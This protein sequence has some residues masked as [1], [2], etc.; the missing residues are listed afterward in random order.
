MGTNGTPEI[1]RVSGKILGEQAAAESGVTD[2][3]RQEE[4]FTA[5]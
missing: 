1:G 4:S 3:E 5:G 2:E